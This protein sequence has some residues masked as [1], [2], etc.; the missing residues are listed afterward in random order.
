[1]EI[2]PSQAEQTRVLAISGRLDSLTSP[3][4]E[5]SIQAA[6]DALPPALVLDFTGV[7]F[8]SSAGLRVLLSAAKRCRKQSTKLALHS[9]QPHIA[10][11]FDM[12]GLTAFLPTHPDRADAL[13][14]VPR[15]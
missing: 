5:G 10:E 14:A 6:L 7:D 12:S 2:K 4:L 15:G 1:M 11:V 3:E 9:L 8:V 13:A